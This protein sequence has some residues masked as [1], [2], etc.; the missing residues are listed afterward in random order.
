METV[1]KIVP[2]FEMAFKNKT[3]EGIVLEPGKRYLIS[4]KNQFLKAE[5]QDLQDYLTNIEKE[6]GCKFVILHG[7]QESLDIFEVPELMELLGLEKSS[8]VP[9]LGV[10]RKFRLTCT[11]S[12]GGTSKNCSVHGEGK[13]EEYYEV[14]KNGTSV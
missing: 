10:S 8:S 1:K 11:C 4:F 13:G 7:Y 14:T 3:G 12:P 9:V 5:V 6:M 2:W